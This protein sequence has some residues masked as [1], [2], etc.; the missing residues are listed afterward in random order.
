MLVAPTEPEQL[1]VGS[2]TRL[3]VAG[4]ESNVA[5]NLAGLGHSSAW[6]SLLGDD[7]FG[8]LVL[9]HLGAAVDVSLVGRRPQPTGVY[10]KNPGPNGTRVLYYRVGSAAS[11]MDA[12]LALEWAARVQPRIVHI[13][14][15]TSQLSPTA[16]ELATA[17]VERR[18]FGDA[19]VSFDVNHR[20][21]LSTDA[22]PDQLLRLARHADIVFVGDDE[23]RAVWGDDVD[24]RDLISAPAHVIVKDGDAQATEYH[25]GT[26]T[27][28][29][30]LTVDVVEPVGAGDAFAAGWLS[31][32][33]SG[34]DAE[35]RLALGH[36][37][38][39]RVLT[40]MADTL[41]IEKETP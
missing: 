24:V 20:P 35:G 17:I 3:H 25:D 6:A 32:Y 38:A 19:L 14:G 18:V 22:T 13:S 7:H 9:D 11:R 23:A 5:L 37:T 33:L 16:A 26:A 21:A 28:V 41:P 36:A 1:R 40:S 4:A 27:S 34:L 31:G 10:F 2:D 39:A 12:T 8:D 29:P 30:A 15:I